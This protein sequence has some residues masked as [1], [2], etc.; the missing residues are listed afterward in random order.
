MSNCFNQQI[1]KCGWCNAAP[2]PM[3]VLATNQQIGHSSAGTASTGSSVL[4]V[5][6]IDRT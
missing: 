1:M 4:M 3:P 5:L 6:S 2:E